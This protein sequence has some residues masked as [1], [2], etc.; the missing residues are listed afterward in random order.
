M[1]INYCGIGGCRNPIKEGAIGCWRHPDGVITTGNGTP[2][3][4]A[5]LDDEARKTI[6]DIGLG[7]Y[8]KSIYTPHSSILD[9]T[10]VQCDL[11]VENTSISPDIA[12]NI[13]DVVRDMEEEHNLDVP[14]YVGPRIESLISEFQERLI[15]SGVD[16]ARISMIRMTGLHRR[17]LK[18]R[19]QN[20]AE[21]SHIV[22]VLDRDNAEHQ[23]V[24]DPFVS[25]MTPVRDPNRSIRE[26]YDGPGSPLSDIPMIAPVRDYV[27]GDY[28][29]FDKLQWTNI[30]ATVKN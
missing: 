4:V 29:W 14:S 30:Q 26:Q 2:L 28:L 16:R 21:I 10:G 18:G 23:T 15:I 7:M 5:N 19:V 11:I 3:A 24:V 25:I 13:I 27:Y 20:A 8:G 9:E 22:T 1:A 12:V 17:T 6:L